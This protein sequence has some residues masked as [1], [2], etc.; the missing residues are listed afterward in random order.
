MPPL[1]EETTLSAVSEMMGFH[2][3]QGE[4]VDSLIARFNGVKHRAAAADGF[5]NE[6]KSKAEVFYANAKAR[7]PNWHTKGLPSCP[8]MITQ[9]SSS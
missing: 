2:R 8:I 5:R 1:G 9:S 6:Y 7:K 3:N 4:S